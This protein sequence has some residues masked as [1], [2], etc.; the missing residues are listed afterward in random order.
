MTRRFYSSTSIQPP[1]T[2]ICG[3][4]AH[5]MLHVL[6]LEVGDR[7]TLFDG[8]GVEYTARIEHISRQKVQCA[9]EDQQ[10]ID[11]ELGVE[12]HLAVALPK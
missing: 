8:S 4:E 11:R 2:E 10:T 1:R 9:I 3:T 7:V 12:I 6:R 5:H